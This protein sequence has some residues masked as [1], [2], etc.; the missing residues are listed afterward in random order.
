MGLYLYTMD[1][2]ESKHQVSFEFLLLFP[3]QKYKIDHIAKSYSLYPR[4]QIR[5]IF[6][7]KFLVEGLICE[8]LYIIRYTRVG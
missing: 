3:Y 7:K 8:I 4:D 2:M 1:D 5:V 6:C